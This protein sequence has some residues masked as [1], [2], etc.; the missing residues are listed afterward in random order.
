MYYYFIYHIYFAS[1]CILSTCLRNSTLVLSS[2]LVF[3]VMLNL[4]RCSDQLEIHHI[5]SSDLGPEHGSPSGLCLIL[6][7]VKISLS[8][9]PSSQVPWC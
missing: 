8:L 2:C 6:V 1:C 3:M 7:D 9:V 5:D 4:I